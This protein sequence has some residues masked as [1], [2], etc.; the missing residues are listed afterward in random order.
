MVLLKYKI[1]KVYKFIITNILSSDQEVIFYNIIWK[2][3][4]LAL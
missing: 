1:Y 2:I 3:N 4:I